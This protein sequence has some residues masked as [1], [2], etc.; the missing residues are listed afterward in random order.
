VDTLACATVVALFLIGAGLIT[1]VCLLVGFW[2]MVAAGG[3]GLLFVRT[4]GSA[5]AKLVRQP[6]SCDHPDEHE[7]AGSMGGSTITQ[8]VNASHPGD[9]SGLAISP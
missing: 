7:H 8:A 3:L 2:E 4:C 1:G 9:P 6:G 5:V